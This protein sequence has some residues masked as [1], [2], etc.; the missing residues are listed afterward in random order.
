MNALSLLIAGSA[1]AGIKTLEKLLSHVFHD[2]GF[3]I[4][5]TKEYESRVRGGSNSTLIRIADQPLHAPIYHVD[6]AIALDSDA[7]HH[8]QSRIDEE[9]IV[10]AD[11][12]TAAD[13]KNVTAIEMHKSAK[14]LGDARY[15]NSYVAGSLLAI[16][17]IP[18][19]YLEK[20]MQS[21][22][23]V[24][25][26]ENNIEAAKEG[27]T[28]IQTLGISSP[29]P[30]LPST[31]VPQHVMDGSTA[32]GFGFLAGGCNMV[33]SYPMSP[34][35]GVL[36]F[37]ASMSLE[38]GLYVEQSED[39]IASLN[40]CLGAWYG[41]GRGLTTTSGGG[42]ALMSEAISLSGM[43]ETPAVIYLAQRPGPATGLP[44]R[45]EQGDLNLALYSGHGDFARIILAPGDLQACIDYGYQAFE[46][47]D[48]YQVPV[49]YLSDQ[50][51][52]D[53]ITE[54]DH[55]DF[56][57]YEQSHHIV[58]SDSD[59][60]RYILNDEGISPRTVPGF[61]KGVM[62]STSDE[63][64]TRGQIT[65][66]AMVRDEMVAKRMA[67]LKTITAHTIAPE[68]NGTGDIAIITWGSTK[69]IV[70]EVLEK[71]S[72]DRLCHVHFNWLY[73]LNDEHLKVFQSTQN[74]VVENNVTGQFAALLKTYHIPI[75]DTILQSNG[76][77]FF[78]DQLLERIKNTV[79]E[80]S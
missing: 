77:P 30:P 49:I 17:D 13:A 43:S 18:L 58:K 29:L 66:S 36:S 69:G 60:K 47:A 8:I 11:S 22:F 38:L 20:S 62:I 16:L 9:S 72:D 59:Y 4:F 48:R 44:T 79:K 1:G 37:M 23:D 42:F 14:A 50:Y 2:Y 5:T 74:I 75:A 3:F 31:S 28:Y 56:T 71:L 53:S 65:E 27:Y 55:V 78:V 25:L 34:S 6:L 46:L 41:G 12:Q 10:I 51:L 68:I 52:A 26:L 24:A 61:G 70:S 76:S 67:K 33:T 7:L 64:D 15:A 19:S 35:T 32:S 73:P 54:V 63:H 40:M 21:L 39:E 57:R 45:T 80:L